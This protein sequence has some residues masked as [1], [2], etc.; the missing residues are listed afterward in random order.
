VTSTLVTDLVL[1]R[2]APVIPDGRLA[3]RRDVPADCTHV[4]ALAELRVKIGPCDLVITSPAQRCVQTAAALW[5]ERLSTGVDERL[6]EQNF[7]AWEGLAFADVPDLGPLTSGALV[8]ARPPEGESFGDVCA[9]SGPALAELAGR[10][11]RVAVVA[12]AGTVRVALALALGARAPALAFQLHPLSM[13]QLTVRNG[14]DWS[15]GVV[16]WTPHACAA[17]HRGCA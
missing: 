5:P 4:Q 7:G 15:I 16:N 11:G 3:G 17:T 14:R 1:I 13:T 6:W 12:H 2:H 9:R 10:G 8:N